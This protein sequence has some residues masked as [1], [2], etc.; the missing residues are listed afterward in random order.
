MKTLK[1]SYFIALL[2]TFIIFSCSNN[3]SSE[4]VIEEPIQEIPPIEFDNSVTPSPVDMTTDVELLPVPKLK[5]YIKNALNSDDVKFTIFFGTSKDNMTPIAT[6]YADNIFQFD[7]LLDPKTTYYW[8][9]SF[10]NRENKEIFNAINQFVTSDI[11]FKDPVIEQIVRDALSKQDGE[12]TREELESITNLPL[13]DSTTPYYHAMDPYGLPETLSGLEYCKNLDIANFYG[14]SFRVP[15][16]DITALKHLKK[17]T[18]LDLTN[19]QVSEVE[20]I[21]HLTD[22]TYLSLAWNIG[23]RDIT[24]LSNL[25]KL[26]T[27]NLTYTYGLKDLSALA[28][29]T[30]LESLYMASAEFIEDAS[31]IGKLTNLKKLIFDSNDIITDFS[32]LENLTEMRDLTMSSNDNIGDISFLANMTKLTRLN[33]SRNKVTDISVLENLTE[34]EYLVLNNLKI[35][36]FTVLTKLSNLKEVSISDEVI[37]ESKISIQELIEALPNTEFKINGVSYT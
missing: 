30:Q 17:V 34:L 2:L 24:P 33:I 9:V 7:F 12:F 37:D 19:N 18:Y 28:P 5:W 11:K 35:E 3:D 26:K 13:T 27:L 4:S 23:L 21:G 15:L 32:F 20:S 36:D 31:A 10:K 1:S 22:L 16:R 14:K 25:N 6:N 8:Q 29:L